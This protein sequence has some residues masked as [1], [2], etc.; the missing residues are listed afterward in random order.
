LASYLV[1]YRASRGP[2]SPSHKG[3][4]Y[5]LEARDRLG[6]HGVFVRWVEYGASPAHIHVLEA[7]LINYLN[8]AANDRVEEH[9]HPLLGE[10]ERLDQRLIR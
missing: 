6:D 9:R 10:Q 7:S 5:I 1:D 3:K 8:P 4:G 2:V